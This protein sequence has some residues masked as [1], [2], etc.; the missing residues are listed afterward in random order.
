MNAVIV[1]IVDRGQ[2]FGGEGIAVNED[3]VD[4]F[5]SRKPY[6]IYILGE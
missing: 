6:F 4:I 1:V 3:V 5:T 2:M